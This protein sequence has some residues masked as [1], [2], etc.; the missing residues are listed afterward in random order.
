MYS[1]EQ[2]HSDSITLLD[3]TQPAVSIL[4]M[5]S[6]TPMVSTMGVKKKIDYPTKPFQRFFILAYRIKI[7]AVKWLYP[8]HLDKNFNCPRLKPWA[9]SIKH[10]N[11]R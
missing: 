4:P 11:I 3:S 8:F 6:I 5:F 10:L 2:Q 9:I 7:E 1:L